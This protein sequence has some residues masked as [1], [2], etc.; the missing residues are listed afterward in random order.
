MDLSNFYFSIFILQLEDEYRLFDYGINVNDV[1]QLMIRKDII[2]NNSP[3][4]L[5]SKVTNKLK[6][7]IHTPNSSSAA[8]SISDEVNILLLC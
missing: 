6:E 8:T 3:K 2:E 5:P 4:S 7:K 1:I